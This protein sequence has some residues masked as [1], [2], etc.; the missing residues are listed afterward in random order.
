MHY[1]SKSVN[2]NFENFFSGQNAPEAVPG[3]WPPPR[4]TA[5]PAQVAR[6]QAEEQAA[7]ERMAAERRRP[8]P[9]VSPG[10]PG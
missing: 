10:F 4:E 1:L 9:C 6:W 5:T 2:S 8:G 3:R 7:A